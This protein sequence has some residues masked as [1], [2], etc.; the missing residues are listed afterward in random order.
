MRVCLDSGSFGFAFAV[1]RFLLTFAPVGILTHCFARRS[2]FANLSEK[3]FCRHNLSVAL[4]FSA[5]NLCSLAVPPPTVR[6]AVSK[7]NCLSP[8]FAV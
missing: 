6:F 1:S 8:G 2:K 5:K 4:G 7:A 3:R